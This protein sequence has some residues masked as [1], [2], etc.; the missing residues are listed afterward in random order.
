M[1]PE[2]ATGVP[3]RARI[4]GVG[5][6]LPARVLANRDLERMVETS[7]AWIVERTGIRERRI[8]AAHESSG[9]MGAR[10]AEEALASAGLTGTDVDL[11]IAATCTPDGIFPATATVIQ[12]AI[13]AGR[14]GSFDVNAAC[15][16]FLTAL[17]V[18]SQFVASNAAQRVLVVGT[19]TLS[20]IVDWT[21]R[22]TCVLFGDGAGAVVL[23]PAPE[24]EPGRLDTPVLRSD[25]ALGE[26]LYA[27]GPS[28]PGINRRAPEGVPGGAA[29]NGERAH[30]SIGEA[31]AAL[32]S[33]IVMDGRN[34]FRHAVTA[35][36]E[37]AQECLDRA[38]ISIDEVALCVPHQANVR[39]LSA[40]ARNLGLPQERVYMNL[41]RYGNTSAASI[42]IALAEACAEGRLAPGDRML[43]VAFGA[44][45]T[46]GATVVEWAGVR[47]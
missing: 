8:A 13:G 37:A 43:V 42:P 7:D 36:T 25:G 18:G 40:L 24:G 34:V 16:G 15:T 44:G 46:W 31:L 11:V 9:T 41:E 23:E 32:A 17:S 27:P 10:A 1:T 33:C 45:L 12:N 21:D 35:M 39:I 4:T 19:E 29:S 26:L 3:L 5:R 6:Y 22:G 28:S 30:G 38:G 2:P 14:A 20:S 47:V